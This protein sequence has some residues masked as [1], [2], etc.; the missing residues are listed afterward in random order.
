ML[1]RETNKGDIEQLSELVRQNIEFHQSIA[2]YWEIRPN[3]DWA[4]YTQEKLESQNR[5]ILIVETS[6]YLAGFIE[7][8]IIDYPLKRG[9]SSILQRIY[10]RLAKRISS[11][12]KPQR[13]GV[14]EEC[15]VIPSLRKQGIGT[16]LVASASKWFKSRNIRRIEISMASQNTQAKVF[17]K[18]LGFKLYRLS[19]FKEI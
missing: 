16:Q 15:F 9:R 17:W 18:S 10:P 8:R 1:I 11:P 13:W 4:T 3:F 14:I 7:L 5:L 6:Q 19:L 12:V 2:C